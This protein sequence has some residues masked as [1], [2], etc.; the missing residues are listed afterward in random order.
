MANNDDGS[1]PRCKI[2]CGRPVAPGGGF[3]TCC[4]TCATSNGRS[5]D[6]T[7]QQ[8]S[9]A[10][11]SSDGKVRCK[12]GCG[13]PT[14]RGFDTCC[15]ACA[16]GRGHDASCANALAPDRAPVPGHAVPGH[17]M[18]PPGHAVPG[19]GMPPAFA[20]HAPMHPAPS[21]PGPG[22]HALAGAAAS[23]SFMLVIHSAKDLYDID[24]TGKMDPYVKA[25]VGGREFRTQVMTNAGKKAK[26]HWAQMVD[27]RGESEIHFQVMDANIMVADGMIGEVWYRGLPMQQDFEGPMELIR[28]HHF[29]GAK[30]AGRLDIE[31]RW[32]RPGMPPMAA[33]YGGVPGAH[34]ALP[35]APGMAP[36]AMPYVLG[37]P[38][39]GAMPGYAPG[40]APLGAGAAG[41]HLFA[42]AIGCKKKKK[43]KK[44]KKKKH[45]HGSSSSSSS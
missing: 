20:G 19:H 28:P 26:F 25:R 30:R 45:G 34:G 6:G 13:R 27:W 7:C 40:G 29:G 21:A 42:H 12:M 33:G 18:P 43:D 8:P 10:A 31:I 44:C 1:R 4:R 22:H 17:G 41:H 24:W 23:G 39:H 35:Y 14:A 36:G 32:Q 5:H 2:G 9:S 37:G 3:D 15:R 11:G 38:H 16:T